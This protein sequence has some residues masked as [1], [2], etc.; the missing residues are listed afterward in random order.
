MTQTS[1]LARVAADAPG[2]TSTVY[3]AVFA[4]RVAGR[5]KRALGD[6]FGIHSFGVNLTM[7]APGAQS[8]L[9]HRH[10]VQEEF[11]YVLSGDL[12]LICDDVETPLSTGMCAGFRPG[13][14]AH[15]L[16]NRS[17]AP[18]TY[19]EIGDRRSGDTADYPDDDLA[20]VQSDG[21]WRFHRKNGEP[22]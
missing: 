16:V 22:Y 20:A 14:A 7:L 17:T 13:G 5:T 2:R 18:A 8:A 4:A 10:T 15:H 21:Q 11:V 12:I 1:P 9:K 3:P 19:L 6:L